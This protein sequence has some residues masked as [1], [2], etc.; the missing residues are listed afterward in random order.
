MPYYKGSIMLLQLA[1][2]HQASHQDYW[3]YNRIY[4]KA[5]YIFS[6]VLDDYVANFL[7]VGVGSAQLL[8]MR[9]ATLVFC[10]RFENV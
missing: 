5:V 4:G 2:R 3:L 1:K 8:D 9:N 6:G 10:Y 7:Y